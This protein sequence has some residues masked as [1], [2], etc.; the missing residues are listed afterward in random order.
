MENRTVKFIIATLERRLQV[1]QY[2]SQPMRAA[3]SLIPSLVVFL[4]RALAATLRWRVEDCCEFATRKGPY[5]GAFWHNRLLM[6]PILYHRFGGGHR[7]NCLTSA[8]KDGAVV[9]GVMERFRIG[10]VRGSSSR[11]G[12]TAMREMAAVLEKG[13]DMAITP[14]GPRGPKYRFHPGAV[15]LAQLTGVPLILIHVEYSRFW[16]LKSWDG[17]RVPKPFSRVDVVFGEAR[18]IPAGL[19]AGEFEA[20]RARLEAELTRLPQPNGY[21]RAV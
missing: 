4:V 18:H 5:V 6:V 9:A 3:H 12:A 10:S 15:K 14:D 16:E 11:R 2:G 1:W 20:E 17:F 21:A 13:E 8:S 7:G 19:S